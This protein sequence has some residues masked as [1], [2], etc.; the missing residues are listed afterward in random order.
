MNVPPRGAETAGRPEASSVLRVQR[1]GNFSKR[2]NFQRFFFT[3]SRKIFPHIIYNRRAR[4]GKKG[5][6]GHGKG[7]GVQGSGRG[8]N[9]QMDV[10]RTR[11]HGARAQRTPCT[12]PGLSGASDATGQGCTHSRTGQQKEPDEKLF[13][14]FKEKMKNYLEYSRKS[15]IFALA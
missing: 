8:A 2:Q 4:E 1:Y 5:K 15:R 12:Q 14:V 3:F 10:S 6:K 9:R 11:R 7:N 13:G